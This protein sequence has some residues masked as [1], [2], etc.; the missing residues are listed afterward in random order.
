MKLNEIKRN[1]NMTKFVSIASIPPLESIMEQQVISL[2]RNNSIE[3]VQKK[4]Q[5]SKDDIERKK[6]ELRKLVG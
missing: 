5:T 3:E 6:H 1:E 4:Y 2:L